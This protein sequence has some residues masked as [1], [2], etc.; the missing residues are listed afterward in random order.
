MSDYSNYIGNVMRMAQETKVSEITRPT[1]EQVA[2]HLRIGFEGGC[3][4]CG[5]ST[6]SGGWTDLNG[7]FKCATCGM[8][9]QIISCKLSDEY[10]STLGL[11]K[12]DVAT[13]HCPDFEMLPIY[14]AYWQETKRKLP[15]GTWMAGDEEYTKEDRHLYG[16][17]LYLNQSRLRPAYEDC[18]NW[19]VVNEHYTTE[20]A[21][22]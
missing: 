18:Y 19:D 15:L 22:S 7:E 20:A 13:R 2:E 8:V 5:G 11:T 12:K 10:L 6:L 21:Q 14:T 1:N 9:Y 16:H 4:I 3:M 17:W